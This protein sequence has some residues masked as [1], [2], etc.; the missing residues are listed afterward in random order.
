MEK[1]I[2]KTYA[3]EE[4]ATNQ[5]ITFTNKA[6]GSLRTVTIENEQWFVAKD[7]C[8]ILEIKNPTD[9]LNKSLE[10]EERARFNLGRQG[11]ANIVNESGFYTLVLRSRKDIAKPF[12]LWVTKEVLPQI[13]KTGG[14]IPIKDTEPDEIILAKA[15]KIAEKTILQK[16]ELIAA[17]KH[18]LELLRPIEENYKILMDTTG[19]FSMNEVAHFV[20]IGE[21]TLFQFLRNNG[22][23]FYNDKRDNVPYEKPTHKNKF[24]A[25]PAIAPD[26]EVHTVTRVYTKGIEYILKL[27]KRHHLVEGAA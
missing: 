6:F 11:N 25:V 23:L 16:D 21:Y 18:R 7:I 8:D 5:L 13:R 20:N 22:V 19:T 1:K 2:T 17:Q 24:I 4:S 10:P 14:Y 3:N 15:V 9:A 26:G 27:L 12:R